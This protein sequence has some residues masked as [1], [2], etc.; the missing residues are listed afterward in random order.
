MS[1]PVFIVGSSEN[2]QSYKIV[3]RFFE[4]SAASFDMENKVF[5]ITSSKGIGPQIID[6]DRSTYRVEEF[7]DGLPYRHYQLQEDT[8][9]EQI[10]PIIC[11]NYVL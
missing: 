8:T 4:S 1:N 7:F 11:N 10:I 3:I 6:T 9:I 5:D 2:S